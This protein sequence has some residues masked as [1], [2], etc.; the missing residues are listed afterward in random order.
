ML[1]FHWPIPGVS[2][3]ESEAAKSAFAGFLSKHTASNDTKILLLGNLSEQLTQVF[4]QHARD[5]Q[6][7]VGPSL[8]AM[9]ADQSLKRSLWH[10]L[11]ANGFA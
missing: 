6:V 9:L 11:I 1:E 7:L 3:K 10:D 2:A 8:E 5:K 4:V